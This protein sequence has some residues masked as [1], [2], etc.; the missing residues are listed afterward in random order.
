MS[1]TPWK[2]GWP[3]GVRDGFQGFPAAAFFAVD[4]GV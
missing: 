2:S 3:S 4:G 1:Q